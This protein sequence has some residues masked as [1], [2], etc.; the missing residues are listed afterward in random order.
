MYP[1]MIVMRVCMCYMHRDCTGDLLAECGLANKDK[2]FRCMIEQAHC[3]RAF[4]ESGAYA[5]TCLHMPLLPSAPGN[6][7]TSGPWL[8]VLHQK[9][10][11]PAELLWP[12]SG[13]PSAQTVRSEASGQRARQQFFYEQKNNLG[14]LPI[15]EA[16]I[17]SLKCLNGTP[18][19]LS[20]KQP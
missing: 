10:G 17:N 13:R 20:A 19:I 18:Y 2:D 4:P 16:H 5:F 12:T 6:L 11:I 14:G 9:D 15:W 8:R 7:G 3:R 1:C